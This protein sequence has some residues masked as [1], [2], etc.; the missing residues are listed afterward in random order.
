MRNHQSRGFTLVELMI[1]VGVIAILAAVAWPLYEQQSIKQRRSDAVTGLTT[2]ALEMDR[3]Y[4]D[5][6]KYAAACLTTVS[7]PKGYYTINVAVPNS[8]SYTLTAAPAAGSP[9]NKD[10]DCTTL[11]LN[12]LGQQG[13]TGAAP[14]IRRC[15]AK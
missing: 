3:C 15:W 13:Y 1:T 11:T 8:D 2:A 14:N 6:G 4:S 7:S 5:S 9:Q 12:Q 10:Q